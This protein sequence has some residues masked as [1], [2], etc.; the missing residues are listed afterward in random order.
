VVAEILDQEVDFFDQ[1]IDAI[2]EKDGFRSREGEVCLFPPEAFYIPITRHD[3]VD[4]FTEHWKYIIRELK[5]K[6]RFFSESVQGFFEGL[7]DDVES[8]KTWGTDVFASL[9]VVQ[10]LAYGMHVYRARVVESED[11]QEVFERPYKEVGPTPRSKARSGRMSPEG[12]VALYCAMDE[13]TAIAELR[14]AIGGMAAVIKLAFTRDLRFLDFERLERSLDDG[15]GALLNPNYDRARSTR[16]FLRKLHHLISQPVVPG[17]EADYLI[18]QTMAEYLAHVHQPQFDGIM[19]KSVQ[20]AGGVNV[21]LFADRGLSDDAKDTFPVEYVTDSLTFHK[22]QHVDYKH[23]PYVPVTSSK[24]GV[25]LLSE[26]EI[27]DATVS[28]NDEHGRI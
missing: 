24:G 19:F 15:W 8:V 10:N 28:W 25:S 11:E 23:D 7:F 13:K 3:S 5:H 26:Q 12:V 27:Q 9:S 4:Y 21:V 2:G 17:H 20:R 16:D 18:T 1:L 14:P 6:R 22:T